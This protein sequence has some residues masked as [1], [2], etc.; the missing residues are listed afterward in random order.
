M[1]NVP[2]SHFVLFWER[3]SSQLGLRCSVGDFLGPIFNLHGPD[4]GT[5]WASTEVQLGLGLGLLRLPHA[6][7]GRPR[8][9]FGR[10]CGTALRPFGPARDRKSLD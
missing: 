4:L 6:Q 5:D 7:L 2:C 8:S 3:K 10:S 9:P 1:N